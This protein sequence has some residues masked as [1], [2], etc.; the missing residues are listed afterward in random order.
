MQQ[1]S[2]Q[3]KWN[4]KF[5]YFRLDA[6]NLKHIKHAFNLTYFTLQTKK[7]RVNYI[8]VGIF[9]FWEIFQ[10][11]K[12]FQVNGLNSIPENAFAWTPVSSIFKIEACQ[13]PHPWKEVQVCGFQ[14]FS[15]MVMFILSRMVWTYT[16]LD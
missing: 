7:L 2:M 10:S 9:F 4:L 8:R 13:H 3:A 6:L 11:E 14:Y 1:Y 16:D 15:S 12:R 5:E